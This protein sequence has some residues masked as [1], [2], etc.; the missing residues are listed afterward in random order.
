[1][2]AQICRLLRQFIG[3]KLSFC[4]IESAL[5]ISTQGLTWWVPSGCRNYSPFWLLFTFSWYWQWLLSIKLQRDEPLPGTR[6]WIP[7][8]RMRDIYLLQKYFWI[9]F[10]NSS[11]FS[12]LSY[13]YIHVPYK[14]HIIISC[15][16]WDGSFQGIQLYWYPVFF[17]FSFFPPFL[18]Y[19]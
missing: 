16:K 11:Y 17:F 1:M 6:V 13:H 14:T 2:V 3:F 15:S 4:D 10:S 12:Y 18:C 9:V 5:K 19:L 7:N 8:R